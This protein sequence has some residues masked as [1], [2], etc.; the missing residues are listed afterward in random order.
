MNAGAPRCVGFPFRELARI[1]AARMI[2][3]DQDPQ[4]PR[5]RFG[6]RF[7]ERVD[8]ARRIPAEPFRRTLPQ[9]G[10]VERKLF[11]RRP[12][13]QRL[14]GVR[15]ADEQRDVGRQRRTLR[16]PGMAG[17]RFAVHHRRIR[18]HARLAQR[19]LLLHGGVRREQPRH[20]HVLQ[21]ADLSRLQPQLARAADPCTSPHPHASS[22]AARRRSR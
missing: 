12:V 4:I 16:I 15:V 20:R 9:S 11:R 17:N 10:L 18:R 2:G 6:M 19:D 13:V 21:L 7:A 5:R 3:R 8:H 22:T 1:G 14:L